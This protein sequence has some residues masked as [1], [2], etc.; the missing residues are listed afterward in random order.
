MIGSRAG[1]VLNCFAEIASV[2]FGTTFPGGTD[3]HDRKAR[4][5]RHGHQ[6]GLP[7]TRDAFNAD[8]LGVYCLVGFEIVETARGTPGPRPQ[9]TPILRLAKLALVCQTDDAFPEARAIVCLNAARVDERV[10]PAVSDQLL[11]SGRIGPHHRLQFRLLGHHL[12]HALQ[13][14]LTAEHHHDGHRT[15]RIARRDQSHLDVHADRRIRRV[16]H[17]AD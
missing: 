16:I 13:E 4:I 10:T 14:G 8:A 1:E 9:R 7:K 6:R 12:G 17:V 5:K 15:V 2:R 11:G 3:Q